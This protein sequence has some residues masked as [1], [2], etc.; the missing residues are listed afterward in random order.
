MYILI[1]KYSL[2]L[3]VLEDFILGIEN[4]KSVDIYIIVLYN[5]WNTDLPFSIW[6][7]CCMMLGIIIL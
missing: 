4:D 5:L 6:R 3:A 1:G 2:F 7:K